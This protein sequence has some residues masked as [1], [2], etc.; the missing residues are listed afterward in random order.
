[1]I[2]T[3]NFGMSAAAGVYQSILGFVIVMTVNK[4]IQKIQPEYALF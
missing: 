4:I 2:Q 3:Q 1:M